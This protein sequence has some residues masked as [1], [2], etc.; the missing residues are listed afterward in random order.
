MSIPDGLSRPVI[1]QV[2]VS[3]NNIEALH[4]AIKIERLRI[5]NLL[6]DI[7]GLQKKIS[8]QD[9][10]IIQLK[11]QLVVMTYSSLGGSATSKREEL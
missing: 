8:V 2:I 5:D 11:Q 3:K 10:E 9:Q 4:Q 6:N 7:V 1:D